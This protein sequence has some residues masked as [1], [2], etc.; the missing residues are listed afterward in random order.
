MPNGVVA[1]GNVLPAPSKSLV[2]APMMGLM[3]RETRF[4]ALSDAPGRWR[5]IQ[6]DAIPM[7]EPFVND[8]REIDRRFSRLKFFIVTP[9]P[10]CHCHPAFS[11]DWLTLPQERWMGL[12]ESMHFD[13]KMF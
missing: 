4:E 12:K 8:R 10:N 11:F 6:R 2:L 5:A 1:P 3:K 9:V 13:R 7:S